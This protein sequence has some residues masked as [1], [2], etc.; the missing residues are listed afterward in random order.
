M[1]SFTR[2]NGKSKI[3][4]EMIVQGKVDTVATALDWAVKRYQGKDCLG[5]RRILGN[6]DNI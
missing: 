5:T 6:N 2:E 4:D 3:Y 1:V